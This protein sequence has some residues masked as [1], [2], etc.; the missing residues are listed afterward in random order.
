MSKLKFD[1]IYIIT[2]DHTQKNYDLIAD[3]LN[4]LGIGDSIDYEIVPGHDASKNLIPDGFSVYENWQIVSTNKWYNKPVSDSEIG[5]TIS[6]INC[7][8]F[9]FNFRR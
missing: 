9:C 7:W 2:L 5:C 6:H 3:K 4:D 1:K 8:R